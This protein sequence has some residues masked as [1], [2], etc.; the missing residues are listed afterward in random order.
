MD[1]CE[2]RMENL[3]L[4]YLCSLHFMF[5]SVHDNNA[6]QDNPEFGKRLETPQALLYLPTLVDR[7]FW[8]HLDS[9][10]LR[11]RVSLCHFYIQ[12]IYLAVSICCIKER[13]LN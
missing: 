5:I 10:K 4:Y 3:Y 6:G 2:N 9:P 13:M 1:I 7:S 8:P 11:K 12:R